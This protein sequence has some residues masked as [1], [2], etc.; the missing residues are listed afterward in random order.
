MLLQL[1]LLL[2]L[3]ELFHGQPGTLEIHVNRI[4]IQFGIRRDGNAPAPVN[5][6]AVYAINA[7][8]FKAN[9]LC[10]RVL[11]HRQDRHPQSKY[12]G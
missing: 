8:T 3:R 4:W 7:H 10:Q 2:L 11:V 6:T 12:H 1:L 5:H 9:L